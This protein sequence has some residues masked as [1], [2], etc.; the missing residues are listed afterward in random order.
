MAP[1]PASRRYDPFEAPTELAPIAAATHRERTT[2]R[3]TVT[4]A[5]AVRWAG[6]PAVHAIVR[7]ATGSLLLAF[8]GRRH[9]A[10]IEPGRALTAEGMVGRRFGR[11]LI[12]NP[13]VWLD[14]VTEPLQSAGPRHRLLQVP[15]HQQRSRS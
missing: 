10:G 13:R 6:G 4:C 5:K 9:V 1:L 15:I 12:I 11:L 8:V 7:D 3:G 14:G 2:V